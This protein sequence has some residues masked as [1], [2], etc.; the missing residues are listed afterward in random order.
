MSHQFVK[1]SKQYLS[2]IELKAYAK[3]GKEVRYRNLKL[4]DKKVAELKAAGLNVKRCFESPFLIH[5]ID[6]DFSA[7]TRGEYDTP[8]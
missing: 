7:Y 1:S 4:A 3:N 2:G 5:L 8:K 6:Y